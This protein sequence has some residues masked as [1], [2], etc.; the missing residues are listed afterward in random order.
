M[1][2][3][4]MGNLGGWGREL[5]APDVVDHADEDFEPAIGDASWPSRFARWRG[6]A[7][8][9][10]LGAGVFFAYVNHWPGGH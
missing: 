8:C 10:S 4:T 6:R 7:I 1:N 9:W 5:Y 2:A 3:Y